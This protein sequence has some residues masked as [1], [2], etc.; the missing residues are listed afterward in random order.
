[1][2]RRLAAADL[3][4][5]LFVRHGAPAVVFALQGTGDTAALLLATARLRSI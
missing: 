5:A 3:I 4:I 1:M 2:H